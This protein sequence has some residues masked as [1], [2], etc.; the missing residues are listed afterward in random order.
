MSIVLGQA[1]KKILSSGFVSC[2]R[3]SPVCCGCA[4]REPAQGKKHT[5][6]W[7]G[8]PIFGCIY[9]PFSAHLFS[10][11]KESGGG[12]ATASLSVS[13]D[14]QSPLPSLLCQVRH[15]SCQ[16]RTHPQEPLVPV[17]V[18]FDVSSPGASPVAH[19]IY[20]SLFSQT[21]ERPRAV[22]TSRWNHNPS[23]L[24]STAQC[25]SGLTDHFLFKTL[26]EIC[27]I[28]NLPNWV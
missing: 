11:E 16:P 1:K 9:F 8:G 12:P 18:G 17:A 10:Q 22:C 27:T 3:R 4:R 6:P 25:L 5:P 23:P 13:P 15:R 21:Q 26:I 2:E 19:D 24:L 7:A 20:N 14:Q 28:N